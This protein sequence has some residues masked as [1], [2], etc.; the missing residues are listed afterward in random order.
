ME[1]AEANVTFDFSTGAIKGAGPVQYAGL[2]TMA[3]AAKILRPL[4]DLGFSYAAKLLR[5][6]LPAG[7]KVVVRYDGERFFLFPYGDAYWSVLL[8]RNHVYEKEVEEFLLA[9]KDIDYCFIDCGANYGY[10][11]VHV[12]SEVFGGHPT[13]AIEADAETYALLE[14]N[15]SINS[16]R[17]EIMCK[18]VAR[19][20]DEIVLVYGGKHEARSIVATGNARP[21]ETVTTICLDTLAQ[22][23]ILRNNKPVVLKLDI[24]GVE[25][26]ALEGG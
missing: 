21:R 1:S 2:R 17:F 23:E 19:T 20:D 15:R 11:S 14:D 8:D 12:T 6:L 18:A 16:N 4:E 10:W 24:E 9:I 25:I 26:A 3:L 7:K 22:N 13:V 5:A